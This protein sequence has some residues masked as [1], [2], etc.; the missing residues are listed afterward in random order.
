M[1]LAICRR[2]VAMGGGTITA[3]SSPGEGATFLVTLPQGLEAAGHSAA[4]I[5]DDVAL[6]A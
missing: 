2:I 4:P 3:T 5:A 6:Q 1:G